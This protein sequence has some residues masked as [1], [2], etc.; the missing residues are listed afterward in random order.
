[1]NKKQLKVLLHVS[2]YNQVNR[3]QSNINNLFEEDENVEISVVANSESI[4]AFLQGQKTEI[5][6]KVNYYV[7]S[8]SMKSFNIVKSDLLEGV[9]VTSTAV[10][11]ITLLQ[12]EGFR[13]IKV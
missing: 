7:C 1:M 10:Y 13:Y 8:N 6:N 9:K 2:D 5:H 11:K 3:M 4:R 12:E